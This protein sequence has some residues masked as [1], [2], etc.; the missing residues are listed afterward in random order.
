LAEE[1]RHLA[2]LRR[3]MPSISQ[4][5]LTEQL[6]ELVAD[7]V[8]HREETGQVP[9]PVVYSLTDY[10]RSLL[11]IAEAARLWGRGHIERFES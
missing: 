1:P 2:A 6:R 5:V 9:A 10:G 11:P 3:L 7:D 4:K 8:V